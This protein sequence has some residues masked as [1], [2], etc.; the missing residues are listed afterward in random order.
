MPAATMLPARKRLKWRAWLDLPVGLSPQETASGPALDIH[1]GLRNPG[2][3]PNGAQPSWLVL[4]GISNPGWTPVRS[5]DFTAPLA[6]AFPGRQV[7]ATRISVGPA[8][9]KAPLPPGTPAIHLP[10]QAP[11]PCPGDPGHARV[12]LAGDFAIRPQTAYTLTI[13]LSG[14]PAA[15]SLPILQDGALAGG[16]ITARPPD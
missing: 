5:T 10:G 12:Q 15:G 3:Y 7:I 2:P 6:F 11:G 16:N 9:R 1:L 14:T 4:I 8:A 13:L